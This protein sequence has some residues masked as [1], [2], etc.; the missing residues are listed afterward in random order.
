VIDTFCLRS[1]T[2][3]KGC[4]DIEARLE[5]LGYE[6][7]Q[8]RNSWDDAEYKGINTRW[9][10]EGG[11]RF[12]VQFHTPE[13]FHAKQYVTHGAYERTRNPLTSDA[14]RAGLEAFQREVSSR[15]QGPRPCHRHS[16]LQEGRV[17]VPDKITFYAVIGGDRTVDNPYGLV[18]RLEFDGDGFT[19]EGLRKD[20]SWAFTTAIVEWKHGDLGQELVEVS[21]EQVGKIIEYFRE[22]WGPYGQPLDL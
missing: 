2:Y 22:L 16:Q 9:V 15:I 14:E 11:Q 12:E 1:E 21:H 8:S 18:R 3:T 13:S 4:N 7:C 20:F 10:T 5:N 6:M 19:D 17:L